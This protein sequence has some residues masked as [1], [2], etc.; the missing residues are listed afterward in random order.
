MPPLL[1]Q[2]L[3]V[4]EWAEV[5]EFLSS[6]RDQLLALPPSRTQTLSNAELLDSILDDVL[7]MIAKGDRMPLTDSEDD[8]SEYDF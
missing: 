6:S 1:T 3:Q 5:V 7:C 2:R 8:D 4:P